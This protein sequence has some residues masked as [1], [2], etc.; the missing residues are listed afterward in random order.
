MTLV[1]YEVQLEEREEKEFIPR[2]RI[3]V[4]FFESQ[5]TY[6]AL[7]SMNKRHNEARLE[8][9]IAYREAAHLYLRWLRSRSYIWP[10]GMAQ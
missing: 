2:L 3:D 8:T 1:V 4:F 10:R 6:I 5:G 7:M 9:F